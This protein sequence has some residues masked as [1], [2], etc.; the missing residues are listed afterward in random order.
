MPHTLLL[1]LGKG[2]IPEL[3]VGQHKCLPTEVLVKVYVL[4]KEWDA[5]KIYRLL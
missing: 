1:S 3:E 2:G 4:T 5:R